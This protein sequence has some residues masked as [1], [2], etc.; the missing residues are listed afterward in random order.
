MTQ[1]LGKPREALSGGI[2]G[3]FYHWIVLLSPK[4]TGSLEN[5]LLNTPTKGLAWEAQDWQAL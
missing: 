5:R 2:S 1:E 3:S 4:L